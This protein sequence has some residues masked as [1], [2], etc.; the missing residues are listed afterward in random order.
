MTNII[1]FN[2]DKSKNLSWTPKLGNGCKIMF[3]DSAW[4]FCQGRHDGSMNSDTVYYI[5]LI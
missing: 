3:I 1:S 2:K 5:F 4:I